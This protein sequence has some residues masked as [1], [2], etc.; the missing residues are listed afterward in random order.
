MT[1]PIIKINTIIFIDCIR[2]MIVIN[3]GINP[4]RGGSPA[5]DSKI[6]NN[7]ICRIPL[8][9]ESFLKCFVENMFKY[10]IDMKIGEISMQ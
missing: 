9:E 10:L 1:D 3:L 4:V 8:Y 7:A 6:T 5:K 2:S